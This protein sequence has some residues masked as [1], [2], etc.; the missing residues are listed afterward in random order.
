M[1]NYVDRILHKYIH[2]FTH[3]EI[4][5]KCLEKEWIYKIC[6]NLLSFYY[7]KCTGIQN[8]CFEQ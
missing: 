2:T 1:I 7:V 5:F 4:K 3:W 6:L 8:K